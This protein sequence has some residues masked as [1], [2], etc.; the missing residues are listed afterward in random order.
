MQNVRRERANPGM[1][2]G[3]A[4]PP[5]R[6][7]DHLTVAIC[8]YDNAALLDRTLEA[9]AR[10]AGAEAPWSVLVVDNNS[11][12]ATAGVVQRHAADGRIPGLR[13]VVETRQG[14]AHARRR[15]VV[16]TSSP[17]L[18]FVDDDCFLDARWVAEAVR[19]TREHPRAGAI[20]GRV[21]LHWEAPP[22]EVVA[23]FASSY[24]AQEYGDAP[25]Q[26][27]ESGPATHLVGAGLVVR[28][29]ALDACG[30]P[31]SMVL[32]DRRGRSLTAG[33]DT[34]IVFRVRNAG[35]ELWYNPAM[36]L[37]HFIPRSRMSV[38]YLCRLQRGFGQ[39]RPITKNMRFNRPPTFGR[40][41]RVFADHLRQFGR[42]MR[43]VLADHWMAGR[44]LSPEQRIGLH[45]RLGEM[46]GAWRFLLRGYRL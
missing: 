44:A 4:D 23:R 39:S 28:R 33:G 22:D 16:E 19:F 29:E 21:M 38:D 30:W 32:T 12:D 5:R 27:V 24:A 45:F 15:A 35:Y 10:S 31:A 36:R 43:S 34:E 40:R 2:L 13:R 8:T 26:V 9:M 17:W 42:L 11:A 20:G 46:E 6:D 18:A 14:L 37:E 41:V 7:M 3:V 25:C 1:E